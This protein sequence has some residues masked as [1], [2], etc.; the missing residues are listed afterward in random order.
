VTSLV[1][2][3]P[4]KHHT[5]AVFIIDE[6]LSKSPDNVA[7]LMGRAYILQAAKRW[8]DASVLFTKVEG[9]FQDNLEIG[10]RAR[11]ERAWCLCQVE[12]FEIGLIGLRD[13]YEALQALDNREL[14]IARC[15]WRLGKC[16]WDIGGTSRT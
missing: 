2:L 9:L 12:D 15:L 8:R 4:P 10:L 13:A 11:E 6:V 16:C 5:R 14:D 7:C 1:H 3:F